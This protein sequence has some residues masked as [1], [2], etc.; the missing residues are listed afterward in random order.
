[1]AAGRPVVVQDTGFSDFIPTGEG[2]L[3]FTTIDEALA[4]IESIRAD[5]SRHAQAAYEIA[6]DYFDAS[7]VLGAMLKEAGL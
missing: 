6:N 5:W 2:V 7:K 4:G 1:M 3:A